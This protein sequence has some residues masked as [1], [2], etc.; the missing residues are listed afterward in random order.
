M[1]TLFTC[2]KPFADPHIRMIQRNAIGSWLQLRPRPEILL[3][4][5]EE[6][7]A[8]LAQEL[9]L[10]HVP[11]VERNEHGTPL[12][13]SVFAMAEAR[14]ANSTL[15]YVNADIILLPEFARAVRRIPFR[16]F[17][18]VG[19]RWNLDVTMPI[20]FGVKDWSRRLHREV[21]K[22]GIL[23]GALAIDYFAFR[24]GLWGQIPPFALGRYV[25]DNW[26]IYGARARRAPVVDATDAVTAIHQNHDYS[27]IKDPKGLWG[28]A[29][30]TFNLSVFPPSHG[31]RVFDATWTLNRWALL[32]AWGKDYRRQ[33]AFH[34]SLLHP[35]AHRRWVWL[36]NGVYW[37]WR[38]LC[39][40]RPC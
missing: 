5:Q 25:W 11:D 39:G 23:D 26:L 31:F 3:V 14:A 32:P 13:S 16:R 27:H 19:R 29:E 33:A 18:M 38:I 17:L 15:C 22:R 4:G 9:G 8:A 6:G 30:A 21:R 1:L 24:K 7:V 28:G 12:V 40:D 34:L 37:R 10:R 20:D 2:P 36:K 35:R